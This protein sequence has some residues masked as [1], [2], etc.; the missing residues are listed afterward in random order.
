MQ[1]V[2]A[3]EPLSIPNVSVNI[4][5]HVPYV[6]EEPITSADMR[7]F[8]VFLSIYFNNTSLDFFEGFVILT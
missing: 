8:D 1:R 2:E 7:I 5:R 3:I 6:T 4:I